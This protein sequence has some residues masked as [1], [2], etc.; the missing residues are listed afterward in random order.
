MAY[1]VVHGYAQ[2][3]MRAHKEGLEAAH[4]GSG[5]PRVW[6]APRS[7][8]PRRSSRWCATLSVCLKEP[9]PSRSGFDIQ[10]STTHVGEPDQSRDSRLDRDIIFLLDELT[11]FGK[12]L[13]QVDGLSA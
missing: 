11:E 3:D 7:V 13:L 12:R 8:G 9:P 10:D 4:R 5:S 1:S 2:H 6:A